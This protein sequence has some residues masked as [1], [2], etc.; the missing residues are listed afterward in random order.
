METSA[1]LPS[2]LAPCTTAPEADAAFES[3][4][5]DGYRKG[6]DAVQDAC[7]SEANVHLGT[8]CSGTGTEDGTE[9]AAC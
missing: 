4:Q 9:F 6:E 8:D 1:S 5:E 7:T 3:A 2:V